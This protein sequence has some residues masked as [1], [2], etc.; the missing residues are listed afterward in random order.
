M[1]NPFYNLKVWKDKRKYI[2]SRDKYFARSA[3]SMGGIQK[4]M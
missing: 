2:L 1:T 4:R 3:R